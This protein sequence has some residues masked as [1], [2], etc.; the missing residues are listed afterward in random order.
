[1]WRNL[2]FLALL[3]VALFS[4]EDAV[5]LDIGDLESKLVVVSNFVPDKP[6]EVFVS[7]TKSVLSSDAT[8]YLP[9]AS[10]QLYRG[11]TF[12]EALRFQPG[13]NGNPPRYVTAEY[14]PEVDSTY[15]L[16]VDVP[17]FEPTQAQS[18]IPKA[19]TIRSLNV[20]DVV[21]QQIS[22]D[23]LAF[24]Y[25]VEIVFADPPNV[26]N[27]YHL[28]FYQQ[29]WNYEVQ[30]GNI[31]IVDSNFKNINFSS[32]NDNNSLIAYFDGG[33]L[34]EDVAFD[35]RQVS[36]SFNLRTDIQRSKEILGKMF[37]E[38]RTTS[39]DYFLYH[40]SLSRQQTSSGGPLTEPVIIY[41]NIE[42]GR[43]IFAGY[44]P[45]VDSVT[46]R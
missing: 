3:S 10:V 25:Q 27:F 22:P 1:M 19:A 33:V 26:H 32:E 34:F 2:G 15:T 38:L 31:V 44:N 45:A 16:R 17:E 21:I 42:N 8:Y 9:N 29:T 24:F 7:K 18:N 35:G 6:V 11:N 36:Y 4:C 13:A 30:N 14:F 43:G 41:N 20:D 28:S 46:I 37:A 40:N 5:E 23:S 39:Q 12:L